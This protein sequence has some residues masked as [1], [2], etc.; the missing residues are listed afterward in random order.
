MEEERREILIEK[1]TNSMPVLRAMLHLSQVDMANILG[2]SRQQVVAI[3][4]K[5]RK[6]LWTTFLA[7]VFIFHNNEETKQLL[8]VLG[9]YTEDLEA[10]ITCK[11]YRDGCKEEVVE[12]G[13]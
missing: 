11:V 9:I 12:D 10:F 4:G 2:I 13:M 5:K 1:L 3:E 7:I 8:E 6:M